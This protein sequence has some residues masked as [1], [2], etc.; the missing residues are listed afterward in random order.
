MLAPFWALTEL[1]SLAFVERELAMSRRPR[2]ALIARHSRHP[3]AQRLGPVN[4]CKAIESLA[5]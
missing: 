3:S 2:P 5:R 1:T 4:L